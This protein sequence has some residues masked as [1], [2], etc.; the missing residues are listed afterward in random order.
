MTGKGVKRRRCRRQE[1]Q[2]CTKWSVREVS[3]L[4]QKEERKEEVQEQRVEN[5]Y[6]EK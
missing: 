4:K 1:E 6:M 3:E 5:V 2:R